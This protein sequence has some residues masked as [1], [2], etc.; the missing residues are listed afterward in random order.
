M[1]GTSMSA[2]VVS[3]AAALL[4]DAQPVADAGAGEAG[5]AGDELAG[6]GCG[7]D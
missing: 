1:S 3:G 2:A 4:L 7:A 6:A 5:A